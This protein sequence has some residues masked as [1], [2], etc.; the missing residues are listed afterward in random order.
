MA[1][2]APFPPTPLNPPM[3]C[4][5]VCGAT[6]IPRARSFVVRPTS[7]PGQPR[8]LGLRGT[9]AEPAVYSDG[10]SGVRHRRAFD[11]RSTPVIN[12]VDEPH[13]FDDMGKHFINL[14]ALTTWV[15]GYKPHCFDNMG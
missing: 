15:R 10:G 4:V 2:M 14:I 3:V 5:Q 7:R 8:R 12:F 6:S 11:G 13:C 9:C 1:E